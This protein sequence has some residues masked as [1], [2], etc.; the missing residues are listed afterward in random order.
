MS[1]GL[2]RLP[3][4]IYSSFCEYESAGSIDSVGDLVFAEI[5]LIC[6]ECFLFIEC[7]MDR[8]RIFVLVFA[9]PIVAA[10][11]PVSHT[12]YTKDPDQTRNCI[13]AHC[14]RG[15]QPRLCEQENDRAIC[16]NCPS[17]TFQD[18]IIS[19]IEIVEAR[20]CKPHTDCREG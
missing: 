11:E 19:S 1:P 7:L 18:S 8:L 12:D 20:Q 3:L 4:Q 2:P 9:V 5:C 10:S 16:D 14:P 6:Y 15:T 17:G 13:E